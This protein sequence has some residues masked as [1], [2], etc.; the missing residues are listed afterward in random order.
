MSPLTRG[1]TRRRPLAMRATRR[2]LAMRTTRGPGRMSAMRT[3]RTR[4]Q[5]GLRLSLRRMSKTLRTLP[6]RIWKEKD[7]NT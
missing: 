2:A 7:S 3:M 6:L 5:R 1:A 4:T